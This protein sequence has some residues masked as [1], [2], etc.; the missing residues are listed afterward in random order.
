MG[1]L[2]AF[3]KYDK[4]WHQSDSAIYEKNAYSY[5]LE[6]LIHTHPDAKRLSKTCLHCEI[7]FICHPRNHK[8]L[9]QYC[10]FGCRVSRRRLQVNASIKKYYSTDDGKRVK[11]KLNASRYLTYSFPNN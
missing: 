8:S 1:K 10:P 9:S 4:D 5:S 6:H 7:Q 11:A 2:Q 3:Y